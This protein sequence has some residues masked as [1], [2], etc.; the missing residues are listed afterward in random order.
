MSAVQPEA[1][2]RARS[3]EAG[4]MP[5]SRVIPEQYE[6]LLAAKVERVSRLLDPY[7]VPEPS[8][9]RSALTGFRMRAE[10][11]M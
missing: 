4:L 9:F 2:A 6:E 7:A 5:L 1:V 8:I 11:R 3:R 10:F